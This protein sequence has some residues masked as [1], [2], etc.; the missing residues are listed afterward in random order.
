MKRELSGVL[1]LDA[2]ALIELVFATR[3]GLKLQEALL[4]EVLDA[5]TTEIAITELRCILCRRLGARQGK[6]RVEKLLASQCIMV[7]DVSELVETAADYKC[8][9]AIS[10]PDCFSISLAK[11]IASPVIF[12]KGEE[13]L[14][15]EIREHPFD[16]EILFL[17][18][19]V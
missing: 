11:K 12:A 19:Y 17:Q 4:E 15:R 10:L 1:A 13:D 5:H 7:E 16:V 18:D 14:A 6:E 2:S 3:G 8:R 9:R